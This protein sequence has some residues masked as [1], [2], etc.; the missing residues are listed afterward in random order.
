[1]MT[2]HACS[3]DTHDVKITETKEGLF[4]ERVLA[5][6]TMQHCSM[7]ARLLRQFIE[8]SA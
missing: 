2:T 7:P 8:V 3:K 1:M 4:K 5:L 6:R